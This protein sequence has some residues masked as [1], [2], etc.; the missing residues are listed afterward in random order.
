MASR[1][2]ATRA[3]LISRAQG[4]DSQAWSE[5]VDLYG[6]LIAHWCYRC[7]LD[8]GQAADVVQDVFVALS[9]SLDTY[10]AGR[11]GAFR[12]WLWRVSSNKIRDFL[13]REKGV[14]SGQGGSTA[15]VGLQQLPEEANVPEHEP[16]D[17]EQV[18]ALLQ[19]GL[20]QV[21]NE[22]ET[23]TWQIFERNV[24][25]QI[26]TALVAEEYH[27]TDAAVRQ[28]RSRILRRLRQQLGDLDAS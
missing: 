22:F 26:A 1:S 28:T 16:T 20:K 3:S 15:M 14:I 13:R 18:H 25:D 17:P 21:R 19:R 12:A 24:I 4:R 10:E 5:L 27:V 8:S 23:R 7:G 2:D 11:G 6:P 9:K